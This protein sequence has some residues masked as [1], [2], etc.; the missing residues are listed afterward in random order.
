MTADQLADELGI[1]SMGVR[2]HLITMER[3]GLVK[4][5]VEQRGQGRPGFVYAITEDGDEFFPRTYPQLANSLIETIRSL[6]GN[7]GV[8]KLFDRRTEELSRQYEERLVGKTL[9]ERVAELAKIRSEEGYM[10]EWE[11]LDE[12][13]FVLREHNCAICQIAKKCQ[14]V[15]SHELDLFRKVLEDAEVT[16][17]EHIVQGGKMC[18]YRIRARADTRAKSKTPLN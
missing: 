9:K 7:E 8:E 1:T 2:R 11:A 3:D 4:Y 5:K 12:R 14:S 10:A 6:Y 18:A 17:E 13:A 16:R 15:C